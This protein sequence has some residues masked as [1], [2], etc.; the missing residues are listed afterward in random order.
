MC[1]H[2]RRDLEKKQ[3]QRNAHYRYFHSRKFHSYITSMYFELFSSLIIT[4]KTSHEKYPECGHFLVQTRFKIKF[5]C[6]TVNAENEEI[7][8]HCCI[9][10]FCAYQDW[11]T[12][13]EWPHHSTATKETSRR[14]I[15][16]KVIQHLPHAATHVWTYTEIYSLA[17]FLEKEICST[18][19]LGLSTNI[20]SV[21]NC[22]S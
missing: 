19:S 17:N 6:S 7:V 16:R 5:L 8:I 21:N 12:H 9:H 20:S 15:R 4:V 1:Y 13:T 14:K 3:Q 2:R 11:S 10:G 18:H 22:N